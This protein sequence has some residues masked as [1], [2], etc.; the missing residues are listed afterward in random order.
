MTP[1]YVRHEILRQPRKSFTVKSDTQIQSHKNASHS[2][3]KKEKMLKIGRVSSLSQL[4][5]LTTSRL[6]GAPSV[7]RRVEI[8]PTKC[9][10]GNLG[11]D[12]LFLINF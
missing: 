5:L 3:V 1:N 4:R 8:E 12:L 9:N 7:Q 6:G 11:E 10:K 2:S